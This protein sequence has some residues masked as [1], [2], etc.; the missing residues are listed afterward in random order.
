MQICKKKEGEV[1]II[2]LNGMLDAVS[3]PGFD[4]EIGQ[5]MEVDNSSLVFD[6]KELQYISSAGL[7]S[8]LTIA[9]KFKAE[10]KKVALT[11]L[12][13]IVKQVFEVSGFNQII[14]IYNSVDE[15]LSNLK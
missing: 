13:N 15:A 4:K 1:L 8:F 10:D 7:R 5:I 3:A 9:K 14:S 11:S 12:Q 2:S 6:M